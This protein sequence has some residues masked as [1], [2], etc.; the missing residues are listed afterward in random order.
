MSGHRPLAGPVS[1]TSLQ[2]EPQDADALDVRRLWCAVIR[3]AVEDLSAQHYLAALARQWIA[4]QET[5]PGSFRWITEQ[6]AL[7]CDSI[8]ARLFNSPL[9]RKE[10]ADQTLQNKKA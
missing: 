6:L 7:D 8:R 4:S 5:G 9:G 3:Q 10:S 2:I 1:K